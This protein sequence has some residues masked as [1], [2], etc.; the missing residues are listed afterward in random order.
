[1]KKLTHI[2]APVALTALLSAC[3]VPGPEQMMQEASLY[4]DVQRALDNP[5]PGGLQQAVEKALE[6]NPGEGNLSQD[7]QQALENSG[8]GGQQQA[9]VEKALAGNPAPGNLSQAM[10]NFGAGGMS[11]EEVQKEV[12]RAVKQ[13]LVGEEELLRKVGFTFDFKQAPQRRADVLKHMAA[14]IRKEFP[15]DDPLARISHQGG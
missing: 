15:S 6:N 8:P 9:A 3:A 2:A 1:M 10:Q 7:L 12:K 11:Q 13:A 4:L 14:V 5:G